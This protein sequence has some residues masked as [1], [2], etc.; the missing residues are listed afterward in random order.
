[1]LQGHQR[2]QHHHPGRPGPPPPPLLNCSSYKNATACTKNRGYYGPA[3]QWVT[4]A[5]ISE[6]CE[7]VSTEQL[8]TCSSH[9][10]HRDAACINGTAKLPYCFWNGTGC[11]TDNTTVGTE[12]VGNFFGSGY[13]PS[14]QH[15]AP[16]DWWKQGL[17][18]LFSA[19]MWYST[20]AGGQCE[21][22]QRGVPAGCSWRAVEEVKR[23]SKICADQSIGGTCAV[24]GA[25]VGYY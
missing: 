23:V 16:W 20:A 7:S 25:L 21:R 19:G 12:T 6:T 4:D 18:R 11:A 14:S 9:A 13:A 5:C 1:M 8:C 15:A 17:V 22:G 2:Q 3:C 24:A 10:H